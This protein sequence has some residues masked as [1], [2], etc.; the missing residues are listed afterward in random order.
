[1]ED[2][3]PWL[4]LRGTI[5]GDWALADDNWYWNASVWIACTGAKPNEIWMGA[6]RL[7]DSEG[8]WVFA[9]EVDGWT[10]QQLLDLWRDKIVMGTPTWTA[11]VHEGR[12]YLIGRD[13]LTAAIY[14][15]GPTFYTMRPF[16]CV[17]P[18]PGSPPGPTSEEM[19][20]ILLEHLPKE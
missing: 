19:I 20:E 12:H 18:A 16:C 14:A 17:D 4:D 2:L 9:L 6:G 10:G 15:A 1:M 3:Y 8:W 13:E 5:R 7:L 11:A